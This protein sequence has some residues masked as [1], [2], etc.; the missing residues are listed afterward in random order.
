[1]CACICDVLFWFGSCV[2]VCWCCVYC[3]DCF[4]VVCVC[5]CVVIRC[6][7]MCCVVLCC[8]VLHEFVVL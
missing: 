2:V 4:V 3:V 1:M 5:V 6:T 8:V 7:V